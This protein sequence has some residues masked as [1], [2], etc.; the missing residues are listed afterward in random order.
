MPITV[1]PSGATCGAT[2]HGVDLR[3]MTTTLAEELRAIWLKHKVVAF[4][5]QKLTLD[6]YQDLASFFGPFGEDP[7]FRTLPD[8]PHIAEIRREAD[9]K[10]PLFAEGWHSD[11][12]FLDKPP[13]LTML[14]G[15]VIPPVG[16]DTLYADQAAAYDALS[17]E[18]KTR[19]EGRMGIHSAR[20][21]YSRAG[22]YGEKDKGRSMAIVYDDGALAT[23]L[24][25]LVLTHSETGV[26]T[27]YLSP[28]YTIGIH[29]MDDAEAQKLLFELYA[30][31]SSEA[32][33]YR[34]TWSAGM[35]TFWDNRT[36]NHAATGGYDG[37][38]RLLHRITVAPR[39]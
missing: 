7:Y 29:D 13:A 27:L 17:D 38:Q 19:L 20:R 30:Y 31:Q 5:D 1:S 36:L 3:A 21:G 4:P 24:H 34:H 14:Y 18:M 2:I 26:K 11:W 35:V 32:F 39:D 9:E 12:S 37:H 15:A 25:P 10:T 22:A 28:G 16:G 23:R 6:E 33:I 8:H